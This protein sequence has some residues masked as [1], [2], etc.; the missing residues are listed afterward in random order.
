MAGKPQC[1]HCQTPLDIGD[2][3]KDRNVRCGECGTIF[4][5]HASMPTAASRRVE[6]PQEWR[7]RTPE[8]QVFG[9]VSRAELE[10]WVAEGR[11]SRDCQLGDS[12]GNWVAA[13]QIYPE[14]QASADAAPPVAPSAYSA[15]A[16]QSTV[17]RPHRGVLILIL[18][19]TGWVTC[20]PLFSIAAWVLGTHDLHEMRAGKLDRAG[21]GSTYAGQVL[22]MIHGVITIIVMLVAVFAL[23]GR[24]ALDG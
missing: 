8:G 16:P 11:V 18:A 5:P 12:G 15:S 21:L 4:S 14:L 7:M 9:P 17:V 23:V 19:V 20:F 13:G 24:F 6:R 1:P 2:V 10:T 22:G 3:E